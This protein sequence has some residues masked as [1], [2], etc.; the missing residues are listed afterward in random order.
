[1]V[2]IKDMTLHERILMVQMEMP[3]M[4]KDNDGYNYKYFDIN[5]MIEI[6]KPLFKKYGLLVLQPLTNIEGKPA[7]ETIVR[8]KGEEVSWITPLPTMQVMKQGE[9][10]TDPQKVG[11]AV[12]YMRR[13]ALQS[14]FMLQAEDKDGK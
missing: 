6:M 4:R 5:Q 14:L 8:S 13:Y 10:G 2:E 3:A 7:I 11:S 12:T 9:Q 1:M